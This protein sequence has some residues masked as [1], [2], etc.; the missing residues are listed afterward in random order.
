MLHPGRGA[1]ITEPAHDRVLHRGAQQAPRPRCATYHCCICILLLLLSPLQGLTLPRS[2]LPLLL[3]Q[4]S[5]TLQWTPPACKGSPVSSYTLVRNNGGPPGTAS[6]G[7]FS[8][9]YSGPDTAAVI[10]GLRQGHEYYVR[11]RA[12]NA[13]S[14]GGGPGRVR[15]AL[16]GGQGG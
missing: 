9:A 14:A 11:V 15:L 16:C 7:A 1:L 13:V 4:T 5:V 6:E 12:S 3:P 10:S 8:L 2:S